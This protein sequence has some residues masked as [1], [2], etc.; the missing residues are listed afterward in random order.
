MS[1]DLIISK[2]QRRRSFSRAA[3]ALAFFIVGLGSVVGIIHQLY[4]QDFYVRTHQIW[5]IILGILGMA[6]IVYIFPTVCQYVYV[7]YNILTRDDNALL[8][9]G[10]TIISNQLNRFF[11][12]ISDVTIISLEPRDP[13]F[14]R[15]ERL[16]L[17]ARNG[18]TYYIRCDILDRRGGDLLSEISELAHL[19]ESTVAVART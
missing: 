6:S 16:K 19:P 14:G 13:A 12:K 18:L 9:R 17:T 8:L 10:D 1:D 5:Y 4:N 3:G 7:L 2:Y 15:P 11:I